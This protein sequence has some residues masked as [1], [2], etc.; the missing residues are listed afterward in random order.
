MRLLYIA[1]FD[2]L[3]IPV[4]FIKSNPLSLSWIFFTKNLERSCFKR[5]RRKVANSYVLR[6]YFIL[7]G[8]SNSQLIGSLTMKSVCLKLKRD[9]LESQLN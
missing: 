3:F 8:I 1:T 9:L 4:C 7:L 5:R 6:L 2:L